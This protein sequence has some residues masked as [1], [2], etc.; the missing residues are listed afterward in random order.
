MVLA[1]RHFV[2]QLF[3]FADLFPIFDMMLQGLMQSL[4]GVA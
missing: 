3:V 4:H 2:A 1:P